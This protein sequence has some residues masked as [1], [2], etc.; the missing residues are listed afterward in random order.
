MSNDLGGGWIYVMMTSSDY[1]RFKVGRTNGNPL[2]RAKT[3]R[4]GDPGVALEAAYFVPVL[5][6]KLSQ[7][8]TS[9][10]C[11]LEGRIFFHDEAASEWFS[12]SAKWACDYIEIMFEGWMGEPVASM[13]MFG[14]NRICRA[15][16]ADLLMFYGPIPM[17]NPIDGL[18]M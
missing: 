4:T 18:P 13:F 17:L 8:E 6:G 3:L 7:I 12:G 14:Q 9:I 5:H 11:E 2:D 1:N 16:E 15:Y 10:H